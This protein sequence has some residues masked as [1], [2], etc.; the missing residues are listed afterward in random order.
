M[1]KSAAGCKKSIKMAE[2]TAK[3]GGFIALRSVL[4]ETDRA[5]DYFLRRRSGLKEEISLNNHN[6]TNV[7]LI[8]NL[9]VTKLQIARFFCD[10]LCNLVVG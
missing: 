3:N 8:V 6:V 5:G 2:I 9:D 4:D 10:F 7:K 1:K